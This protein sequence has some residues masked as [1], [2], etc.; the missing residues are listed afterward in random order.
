VWPVQSLAELAYWFGRPLCG[1]VV[2]GGETVF[3]R[4]LNA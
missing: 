1:R 3:E 4:R 2:R